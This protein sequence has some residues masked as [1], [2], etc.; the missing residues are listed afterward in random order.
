M[1]VGVVLLWEP[2]PKSARSNANNAADSFVKEGLVK[3]SR[4]IF[5]SG[6]GIQLFCHNSWPSLARPRGL[7]CVD[8]VPPLRPTNLV[9]T[10]TPQGLKTGSLQ[11]ASG[12]AEALIRTIV[13]FTVSEGHGLC[14]Q[15]VVACF[16]MTR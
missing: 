6:P 16:F 5:L 2:Q 3:R 14:P 7:G 11:A 10:H 15:D 13:P 1:V 8:S 9:L 4:H 12:T